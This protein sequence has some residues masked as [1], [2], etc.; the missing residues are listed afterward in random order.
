MRAAILTNHALASE[1]GM[2]FIVSSRPALLDL[3]G[4]KGRNPFKV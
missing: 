1:R 4:E 3:R 2:L